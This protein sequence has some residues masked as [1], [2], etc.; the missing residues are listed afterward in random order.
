[1]KTPT[2]RQRGRARPSRPRRHGFTLIEMLA[3]LAVIGIMF[4]VAVVG[5]NSF[6]RGARLR[7][8]GLIIGQQLDLARLRALTARDMYGV[9]F[10]PRV[11]PKRDRVCV[12]FKDKSNTKDTVPLRR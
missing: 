8:A 7:S 11:E 1:M 3:V 6:G 2:N 9:W 10:D 12:Y 4:G 5:F